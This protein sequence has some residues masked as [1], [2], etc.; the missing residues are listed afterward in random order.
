MSKEL[1]AFVITVLF[2]ESIC[3]G[4]QSPAPADSA[5]SLR[6]ER[7]ELANQT[8]AD[9]IRLLQ[10]QNLPLNLGFEMVLKAKDTDPSPPEVHFSLRRNGAT[11]R[12]ILEALCGMDGRYTWSQDGS[13]VNVYPRSIADDPSYLLNRRIPQVELKEASDAYQVLNP[14]THNLPPPKEQIGY[15]H[16]GGDVLYSKPWTTTFDNLT[17]RQIINRATSHLG[18]HGGWVFYGS[19]DLRWFTF[20]KAPPSPPES[21]GGL[22]TGIARHAHSTK[23]F[24]AGGAPVALLSLTIRVRPHLS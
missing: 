4:S 3:L 15:S 2:L 12:E 17:V 14:I 21:K 16:V 18:P 10:A 6:V 13:V 9:G 11:V 23:E 19:Q 22:H 24:I 5:L 1:R 20:H 8:F 7:F